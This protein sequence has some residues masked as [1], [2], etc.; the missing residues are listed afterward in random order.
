MIRRMWDAY[1]RTFC[2]MEEPTAWAVIIVAFVGAIFGGAFVAMILEQLFNFTVGMIIWGV[3]FLVGM[4][5][6]VSIEIAWKF[7]PYSRERKSSR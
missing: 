3:I 6:F 5:I 4:S 7:C 1:W 2:R